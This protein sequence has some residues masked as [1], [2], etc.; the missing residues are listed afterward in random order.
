M[1]RGHEVSL[2]ERGAIEG[3]VMFDL[4]HV[5]NKWL[6]GLKYFTISYDFLVCFALNFC[7]QVSLARIRCS[8]VLKTI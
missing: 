7:I 8:S 1:T 2:D 4:R 5:G 3:P 6:I